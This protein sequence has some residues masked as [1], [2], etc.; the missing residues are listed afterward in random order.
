MKKTIYLLLILTLIIAPATTSCSRNNQ[1]E[2]NSANSTHTLSQ[3]FT[4]HDIKY[5]AETLS[6]FSYEKYMSYNIGPVQMLDDVLYIPRIAER[7]R[8]SEDILGSSDIP[9]SYSVYEVGT[10]ANIIQTLDPNRD[11]MLV[12][13]EDIE[14][15]VD[16]FSAP[17][18]ELYA[19]TVGEDTREYIVDYFFDSDVSHVNI[20]AVSISSLSEPFGI[21]LLV[22]QRKETGDVSTVF[23]QLTKHKRESIETVIEQG[24]IGGETVYVMEALFDA[25]GK[26]ILKTVDLQTQKYELIALDPVAKKRLAQIETSSSLKLTHG[27]YG[28]LWG[29]ESSSSIHG[30][31]VTLRSLDKTTWTWKPELNLPINHYVGLY[32]APNCYEFDWFINTELG[33]YGVTKDSDAVRYITWH[34]VDVRVTKDTEIIFLENGTFLLLTTDFHPWQ[35]GAVMLET[36]LLR[37]TD[38]VDER[39]LLII[40]GVNL[41]DATLYDHIRQ[42]NRESKSHRALLLDY[43]ENGEWEGVAVRLRTDLI[44]G[45]GPDVIIFNQWGDENDITRAL[46]QGGFLADLS[47]YL[48]N[49]PTLS[50]EDFFE[51]ILDIWTNKAGELALITG[52]VIPMPFWGPYVKLESFT[53]FTHT[54]FIE[55]LRDSEKKGITYPAGL[56]FLPEVILYTMLFADNTFI[57]FE[58]GEVNFDSDL[59]MDILSYANS[60]PKEQHSRWIEGLQTGESTHPIPFILRGEQLMTNMHNFMH[61]AFFR[62]FD[63]AVGGLKPVGAP[64]A[65]G[66]L[67]IPSMPIT[68]MGIRA[69]SQNADAAWEF[70]RIYVQKPNSNNSIEGIPI[71]RSLFE[72]EVNMALMEESFLGGGYFTGGNDFEVPALTE[73]RAAVLRLIMESITHEYHP[74]PH[75]MA[76]ILEDTAPFFAGTRSAEDTARIIQSRVSRYLAELS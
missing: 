46:M 56:N 16:F 72:D 38:V 65:A 13:G 42:F 55:F 32:E 14:Y 76:I 51:N 53:D 62:L 22:N 6:I 9:S 30:N 37:R 5:Q 28:E 29:I 60:I 43:A 18:L 20:L 33:L 27:H 17:H 19:H 75:I 7:I 41:R 1:E 66:D 54:G 71:L 44:A 58:S 59:F 23:I 49:D 15:G 63:A 69:N 40:G 35:E 57:C 21:H 70:I 12:V 52:T 73:E 11:K 45:R 48:D 31:D 74:D 26:I 67:A 24:L 39:E 34:D 10:V 3:E 47:Y 4:I 64:N 25:E 68:R 50:R 8:W 36:I 2:N 61:I